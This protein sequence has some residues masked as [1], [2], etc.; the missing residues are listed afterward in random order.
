MQTA[1][2]APT[3]SQRDVAAVLRAQLQAVK[4]EYDRV[5]SQDVAQFNAMLQQ[6]KIPNVI[7]N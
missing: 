5:M 1:D 4:A 3:Q 2:I 6:R 7:T